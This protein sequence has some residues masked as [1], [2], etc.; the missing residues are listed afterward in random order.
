MDIQYD[1]RN[2]GLMNPEILAEQADGADAIQ[3]MDF[4]IRKHQ[5]SGC[6]R[7]PRHL[8]LGNKE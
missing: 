7:K 8:Y 6:K 1:H 3:K 5:L 2:G 4:N